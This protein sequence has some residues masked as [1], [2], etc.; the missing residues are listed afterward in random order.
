MLLRLVLVQFE[1]LLYHRGNRERATRAEHQRLLTNG[2]WLLAPG[3]WLAGAD[4][5]GYQES[6]RSYPEQGWM[7][8]D[9]RPALA[10]RAAG[11]QG[12]RCKGQRAAEGVGPSSIGQHAAGPDQSV[13]QSVLQPAAC[14]T[15]AETRQ[16]GR[17]TGTGLMARPSRRTRA[18]RTPYPEPGPRCLPTPHRT[19]H[20]ACGTAHSTR[21]CTA[22]TAFMA[23]HYHTLSP[24]HTLST[25]APSLRHQLID[26]R[27]HTDTSRRRQ[28][29][30]PPLCPTPTPDRPHSP[31][32]PPTTRSPS[33]V[34][35]PS[36]PL[37][38]PQSGRDWA[39]HPS[40]C[41]S[42]RDTRFLRLVLACL[43]SVT[44]AIDI[45]TLVLSASPTTPARNPTTWPPYLTEPLISRLSLRPPR[46]L[47]FFSQPSDNLTSRVC[48]ALLLAL[49]LCLRLPSS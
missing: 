36:F 11:L 20:T 43:D 17:S 32:H 14:S 29:I 40:S 41:S 7:M 44:G 49:R 30:R 10:C 22:C 46:L 12:Y 26:P 2:S 6:H 18:T 5:L 38:S 37:P 19:Q 28:L 47:C 3:C 42:S 16:A 39:S 27:Y 45:D 8:Q 35:T 13:S 33:A 23:A 15:L 1:P 9:R 34:R 24:P 48:I 21:P 31:L 25:N 4:G